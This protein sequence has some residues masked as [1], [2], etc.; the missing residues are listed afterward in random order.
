MGQ[1]FISRSTIR[2]ETDTPFETLYPVLENASEMDTRSKS[3]A[4]NSR[5]RWAANTRIGNVWE[6]SPGF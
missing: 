6:Y 1:F 2:P 3:G 5:P 4:S